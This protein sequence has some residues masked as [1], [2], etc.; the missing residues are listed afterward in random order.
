MRVLYFS[1]AAEAAGC[2]EEEWSVIGP[3]T[4]ARFWEEATRRHPALTGLAA[5]CRLARNR[6][7]VGPGEELHPGDEIAVLPPV[8]GG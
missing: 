7:Y 1:T 6:R 8:S 2:S 5:S 4:V 3:M